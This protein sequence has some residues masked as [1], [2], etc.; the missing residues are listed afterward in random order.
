MIKVMALGKRK[1]GISQEEFSRHW[2]EI[3]APLALKY[4]RQLGIKRYIQ[5]HIISQPDAPEPEF[6]GI[7]E[8]WFENMEKF[9][10]FMNFW[11][12]EA[13]KVVRDDED[14]FIDRSTMN[15]VFVEENIVL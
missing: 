1:P 15:F 14:S 3:H 6:A 2:R 11:T 5:N 7:T 9:N 12:S 13:G 8:V 10:T 4:M